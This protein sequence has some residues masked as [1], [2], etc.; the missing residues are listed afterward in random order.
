[1]GIRVAEEVVVAMSP[2]AVLRLEVPQIFS[3]QVEGGL[4]SV[5]PETRRKGEPVVCQKNKEENQSEKG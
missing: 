4:R 1:V 2:V 3:S 5:P